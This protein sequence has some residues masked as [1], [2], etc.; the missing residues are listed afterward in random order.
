MS[1][2]GSVIRNLL[3]TSFV[4]LPLLAAL[5]AVPLLALAQLPESWSPGPDPLYW[6]SVAF[7]TLGFLFMSLWRAGATPDQ[8]QKEAGWTRH[9]LPLGQVAL[10][11]STGLMAWTVARLAAQYDLEFEGALLRMVIW[12]LVSPVAA[13]TLSILLQGRMLHRE[14]AFFRRDLI[15]LALSGSAVTLVY[16]VIVGNWAEP[17]LASP[18]P[19]YPMFAPIFFIGPML[20]AQALFIAFA[21][22]LANVDREWWERYGNVLVA[23]IAWVVASTIVFF[24]P[25]LLGLARYELGSRITAAG[26]IGLLGWIISRLGQSTRARGDGNSGGWRKWVL[27]MAA[28]LFCMALLLLVSVMTQDLLRA[29]FAQRINY[30]RLWIPPFQ[31][32]VWQVLAAIV[33]LGVIGLGMGRLMNV[34]LFSLQSMYR[35]HLIAFGAVNPQRHSSGMEDNPRLDRKGPLAEIFDYD[36]FLSFA[37]Q[38]LEAVKPLWQRLKARGLRVFWSN[39]TLKSSAGQSYVRVIQDALVGSKDFVL[40]WSPAAKASDW[41]EEEYQTF[42]RQCYLNDKS[43]RRLILVFS[44]LSLVA[45]LPPF[46]SNLQSV[47]TTDEL[48]R[49]L[50]G[51]D[52]E[53]LKSRNAEFDKEVKGDQ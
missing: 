53:Y 11:L 31:G 29:V 43:A 24:G 9:F 13:F 34:S 40:Y 49:V 3:L 20:V 51:E 33:V 15:A 48:V 28:P 27:A 10:L 30:E 6:L 39:E 4:M 8:D 16:A 38:D 5:L 26:F 21:S 50:G 17:L 52:V 32:E 14:W 36:V 22:G 7:G 45:S 47:R 19:L 44:D 25:T 35:D 12:S 41:V 1:A 42:F 46:L 37:S 23:A 18:Y 2:A